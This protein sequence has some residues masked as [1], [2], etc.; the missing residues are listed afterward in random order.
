[1]DEQIWTPRE[2][3]VSPHFCSVLGDYLNVNAQSHSLVLDG[4]YAAGAEQ[5]S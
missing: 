1:M 2:K 3:Q 4:I 5:P